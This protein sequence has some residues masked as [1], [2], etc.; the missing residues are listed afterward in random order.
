MYPNITIEVIMNM[1][2]KI[3]LRLDA[4]LADRLQ[5]RADSDLTLTLGVQPEVIRCSKATDFATQLPY[6]PTLRLQNP[7]F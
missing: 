3:K 2:R 5:W 4:D 7:V 6:S 1:H